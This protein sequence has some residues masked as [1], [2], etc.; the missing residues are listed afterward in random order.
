[1]DR[2]RRLP[3]LHDSAHGD[4]ICEYAELADVAVLANKIHLQKFFV[5]V[6]RRQPVIVLDRSA[7]LR[8]RIG[9]AE[10]DKLHRSIGR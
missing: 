5:I 10:C 1:L 6:F 8:A 7:A 4:A 9:E 2:Y 3:H